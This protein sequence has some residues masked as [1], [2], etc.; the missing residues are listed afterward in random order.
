MGQIAALAGRCNRPCCS[1]G[2]NQPQQLDRLITPHTQS[3]PLHW[4]QFW[5][6]SSHCGGVRWVPWP[7]GGPRAEPDTAGYEHRSADLESVLG[8]TPREFES[9]IL[10]PPDQAGPAAG[11]SGQPWPPSR[12]SQ[13]PS[14]SRAGPRRVDWSCIPSD[15][16]NG[17]PAREGGPGR[18]IRFA[19][20]TTD[21]YLAQVDRLTSPPR[22][23]AVAWN[24]PDQKPFRP[25]GCAR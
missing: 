12:A 4:S 10:R 25:G 19:V 21:V 6:C 8:A 16:P 2:S 3:A 18:A 5:S 13:F 22:Q 23:S 14:Q 24:R 11:P 1:P 15:T 17:S 7:F 20:G 9:R